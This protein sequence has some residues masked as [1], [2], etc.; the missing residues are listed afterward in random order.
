MTEQTDPRNAARME[1]VAALR[2]YVDACD[3]DESFIITGYITLIEVSNAEGVGGIWVSGN[4]REPNDEDWA[5]LPAMRA[6]GLMHWG[7]RE[8]FES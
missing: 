5:G 2:H 7:M 4:G 3:W 8:L 1:L 6:G